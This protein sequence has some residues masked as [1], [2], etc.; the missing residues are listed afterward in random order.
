MTG[1]VNYF[2]NSGE[3]IIDLGKKAK[4]LK[5]T[6]TR[7][8]QNCPTRWNS[9]LAQMESIVARLQAMEQI[10]G[11]DGDTSGSELKKWMPDK[12]EISKVKSIIRILSCLKHF[13]TLF[14]PT[15]Q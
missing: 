14:R 13:Q 2:N 3:R 15:R 1:L 10:V 6:A 8:V 12:S 9:D 7:L 11:P 4:A 5:M